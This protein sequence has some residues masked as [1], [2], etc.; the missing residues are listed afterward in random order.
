MA[1][2]PREGSCLRWS[3]KSKSRTHLKS[4]FLLSY[5]V[6][7]LW[8][9]WDISQSYDIDLCVKRWRIGQH[10]QHFTVQWFCLIAW[11]LFDR[12]T[13]NFWKMSP[14]DPIFDLKTNM[15]Q[16]DLCFMVQW[17]CLI[18]WLFDGWTSYFLIMSQWWPNLWP[19]NKYRSC[20]PIFQGPVNS[21]CI[22]KNIWWVSI[23]LWDHE[24]VWFDLWLQ[25]QCRSQWPVFH[26]PVTLPYI[27]KSFW[28]INIILLDNESVW[29][30]LWTQNEYR[31]AWPIFYGSVN[32][33]YIV[34]TIWWINIVLWNN[35]SVW[36]D[37]W[38]QIKW[39]S[40][41]PIFHSPVI[42]SSILKS[43]WN[44]VGQEPILSNSTSFPRPHTGKEHK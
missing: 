22:L 26:G 33:L 37:L 32:L 13:S 11:R 34:N 6:N 39:W 12:S 21:P 10:D 19:Q 3:Q 28:W 27:L 25:I 40:Q 44:C 9:W 1:H 41:W 38:H 8:S 35:E 18:S 16:N 5:Y 2:D 29:P 31:W 36:H 7:S 20:W 23:I 24:S 15:G 14:C 30:N 42:L 4:Y 43:R 17:F